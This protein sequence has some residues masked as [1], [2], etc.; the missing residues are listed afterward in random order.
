MKQGI[1]LLMTMVCGMVYLEG[2]SSNSYAFQRTPQGTYQVHANNRWAPLNYKYDIL[3]GS[4][5]DFS[6]LLDAPAGKYGRLM[7]V[8]EHFEFEK[9]PGVRVRFYGNHVGLEGITKGDCEKLAERFARMGYNSARIHV[10]DQDLQGKRSPSFELD[11]IQLDILDYLFFCMKSKGI[12]L[13]MDLYVSRELFA[14]EIPEFS[15]KM[16]H[17]IKFLAHFLDSAYDNWFRFSKNLLTHENPYTKIA[18]KDDPA[19]TSVSLINEDT[20]YHQMSMFPKVWETLLKPLYLDWAKKNGVQDVENRSNTRRFLS[21]GYISSFKRMKKDLLALGFKQPLTD[22]NFMEHV[23]QSMIRDSLDYVDEHC[24]YDHPIADDNQ[25]M[26]SAPLRYRMKL[27][28]HDF[29]SLPRTAMGPR[30]IGKPFSLSEFHQPYPS[31]CRSSSGMIAASYAMLQDA[32][33]QVRF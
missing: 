5:L 28:E 22:V 29:A 25:P 6:P 10:Y 17:E 14:N 27:N 1:F 8:N 26:I 9:R 11:V 4:I 2:E 31:S 7:I 12:Y 3:P 20:P 21:E 18:W 24:Y 13:T 33:T 23:Y 16:Q 30:I 15:G 19:L 32:S